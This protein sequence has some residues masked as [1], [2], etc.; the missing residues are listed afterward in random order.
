MHPRELLN[1]L[2]HLRPHYQ[3]FILSGGYLTGV[4]IT[5]EPALGR[6]AIHFFSVHLLLFGGATAYNSFFDK[7]E[8]PIGGLRHPPPMTAWMHP[9]S[10]LIQL[11]GLLLGAW[12]LGW[13]FAFVYLS[14]MLFFWLYSTPHAR[15]K[16]HPVRSFIAIGVSTGTN[17]VLLGH[18]AAGGVLWTPSPP[19]AA[20]GVA[21]V[22]LSMYPVSQV[23][24]IEEDQRRGDRTFAVA[25]GLAGIRRWFALAYPAGVVFLSGAFWFV[26]PELALFF[27]AVSVVAFVTVRR[28]LER[29]RGLADEYGRVMRLKYVTS[30]LFVSFLIGAV[31]TLQLI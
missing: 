14:S 28:E 26:R 8:G 5:K 19:L 16:G 30:L 9:A 21:L 17:S 11:P 7:D 20:I 29:M 22:L 12:Q 18:L 31:A 3:L 15:W 25:H 10:L 13:S 24:Q 23:F 2:L 6:A 4:L 27:G 1:F